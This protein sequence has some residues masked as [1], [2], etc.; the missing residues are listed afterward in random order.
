VRAAARG[1]T[2]IAV[3]GDGTT[4]HLLGAPASVARLI[5]D[6]PPLRPRQDGGSPIAGVA[7]ASADPDQT[8]GLLALA[9]AAPLEVLTTERVRRGLLEENA[10]FRATFGM[11]WRTIET[12][13]VH[14]V[15]GGLELESIALPVAGAGEEEATALV[16]RDVRGRSMVF[17][18]RVAA[19]SAQVDR[20]LARSSV[21]FFDG[22]CWSNTDPRARGHWPIGGPEGSL[23]LLA[24]ARARCILLH[25]SDTNPIVRDDS[26]ER[27]AV[28][29]ARVEVAF[30]GMEVLV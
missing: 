4:W 19:R 7:L 10:L 18:P 23:E 5:A 1:E 8:L 12:G 22:T 9:G 15:A 21:V 3:S 13:Q 14:V 30:D 28:D 11:T 27:R 16:L 6:V 2:S 20:L 26:P 25:V 17:A 24:G 29:R